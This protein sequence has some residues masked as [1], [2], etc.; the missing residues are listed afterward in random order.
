MTKAVDL[1]KHSLLFRKL[2]QAGLPPILIRVLLFIYT[3]QYANVRWDGKVSE[4][5]FLCNGVRQ[6]VI[7]SVILYC[8]YVNDLSK[9]LRKRRTGRWIND[10]YHGITG[11]I[12]DSFL[13]APT[14][15]ASQEML[16]TCQEFV[17]SQHRPKPF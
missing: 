17:E 4:S 6:G 13:L 8:F 10:N 9:L 1:I 12:N 3:M 7:L 15:S 16:K 11:Y 14:I 2:L 5:F